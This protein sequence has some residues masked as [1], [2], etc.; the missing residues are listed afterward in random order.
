MQKMKSTVRIAAG[1]LVAVCGPLLAQTP[2]S[3]K[4]RAGAAKVD[5]T[6]K[7]SELSTFLSPEARQKLCC[8]RP[9]SRSSQTDRRS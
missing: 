5:I 1:L 9:G 4:L 6:P 7:E 2:A 8:S 3:G